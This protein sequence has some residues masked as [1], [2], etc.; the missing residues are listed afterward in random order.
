MDASQLEVLS[1]AMAEIFPEDGKT[2]IKFKRSKHFSGWD[3]N[4]PIIEATLTKI[5]VVD[6]YRTILESKSIDRRQGFRLTPEDERILFVGMNW[7]KMEMLRLAE[8]YSKRKIDRIGLRIVNYYKTMYRFEHALAHANMGLV[9]KFYFEH[10]YKNRANGQHLHRGEKSE[11]Q[12]VLSESNS[13]LIRA[14]RGFEIDYGWCFSTYASRAIIQAINRIYGPSAEDKH[15]HHSIRD[16]TSVVDYRHRLDTTDI[17]EVE[18]QD[19]L[20]RLREIVDDADL[21]D[22]EKRV[23]QARFLCEQK[24]GLEDLGWQ[25]S[26]TKERVR[27]IETR[28]LIKLRKR[29]HRPEYVHG[30]YAEKMAIVNG[31]MEVEDE[32]AAKKEDSAAVMTNA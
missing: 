4:A 28:A 2:G 11:S 25:M 19:D 18:H 1:Q 13:A 3:P 8:S 31:L 20:R 26:I 15:Y 21:S 10:L 7:V 32:L 12:D 9:L 17:D 30:L 5:P 29:F 6:V 16:N 14:I 23:I 24:T 22:Q 27:Q